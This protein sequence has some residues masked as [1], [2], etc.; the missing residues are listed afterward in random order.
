MSAPDAGTREMTPKGKNTVVKNIL[1]GEVWLRSR[2]CRWR[3]E[4]R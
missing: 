2:T 1:A 4:C 3:P